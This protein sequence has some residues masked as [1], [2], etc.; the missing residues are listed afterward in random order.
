MHRHLLYP[1]NDILTKICCHFVLY[2]NNTRHKFGF[3]YWFVRFVFALVFFV[4][5][6]AITT[7]QITYSTE[8]DIPDRYM[9]NWR[10]VIMVAVAFGVG[11]CGYEAMQFIYAPGKYIRYVFIWMILTLSSSPLINSGVIT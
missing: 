10:P 4:L 2:S 7:Y 6:V 1:F 11:L 3:R 8:T 9:N 5:I